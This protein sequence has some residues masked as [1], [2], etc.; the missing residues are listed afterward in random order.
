M[1]SDICTCRLWEC[2]LGGS[3]ETGFEMLWDAV[4]QGVWRCTWRPWSSKSGGALGG[5]QSDDGQYRGGSF[6]LRWNGRWQW[7]HWISRNREKIGNQ[8]HHSL[9]RDKTLA[10]SQSQAILGWYSMQC[11]QHS[12]YA[13]L[14][15]FCTQCMLVIV[16]TV[17]DQCSTQCMLDWVYVVH[18]VCGTRC[19]LYSVY[20]GLDI[21]CTEC[22]LYSVYAIISFNC[23]S[24]NGAIERDNWTVCSSVMIV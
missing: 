14:S 22:K 8:V 6:V 4:I 19:M 5:S 10:G 15:I 3:N 7:R 1:C 13:V 12:V 11:M 21:C 18:S 23:W 24:L 16:Y 9:P 17:L 20:A 2:D